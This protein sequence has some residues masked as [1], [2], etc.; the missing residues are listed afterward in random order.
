[1]QINISEGE[2]HM[3]ILKALNL[4]GDAT[5]KK[6]GNVH[7]LNSS[8]EVNIIGNPPEVSRPG[9][10]CGPNCTCTPATVEDIDDDAFIVDGEKNV[11]DIDG[12]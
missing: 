6:R 8:H 10:T 5:L 9:R 12:P 4:E 1:M 3:L 2:A 11:G 7:T